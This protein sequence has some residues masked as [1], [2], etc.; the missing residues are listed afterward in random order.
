GVRPRA[1]AGGGR[2]GR[3]SDIGPGAAGRGIVA[4]QRPPGA[5]HTDVVVLIDG[6]T[7]PHDPNLEFPPEWLRS[8][9]TRQCSVPIAR[10]PACCW[11]AEASPTPRSTL[12]RNRRGA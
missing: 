2:I 10:A 7:P 1:Q 9:F 6:H 8:S 11:S 4:A 12:S 3:S 5:W